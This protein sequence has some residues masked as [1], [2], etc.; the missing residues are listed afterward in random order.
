MVVA[1]GLDEEPPVRALDSRRR[2]VEFGQQFGHRPHGRRH[3]PCTGVPGQQ[4]HQ[5]GAQRGGAA[6]LQPDDGLPR[7][8]VRQQDRHG[9]AQLLLGRRELSGRDQRQ[10]A[11]GLLTGRL[12][13]HFYLT[14]GGVQHRQGSAGI[15]GRERPRRSPP[16]HHLT[17]AGAG[18][19]PVASADH[20]KRRPRQQ[21][22]RAPG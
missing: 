6:G 9:P 21:R 14:P 18:R 7:P 10:P 20:R 2:P 4:L 15:S 8:H 3:L 5:V 16:Q 11:A 1:V 13:D 17:T 12:P 22:Q 19:R